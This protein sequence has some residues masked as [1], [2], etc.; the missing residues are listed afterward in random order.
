[1]SVRPVTSEEKL[2]STGHPAANWFG[3]FGLL[4]G[5]QS[6]LKIQ[7]THVNGNWFP[8]PQ[9]KSLGFFLMGGGFYAGYLI[10][11]KLFGNPELQRL[12]QS[13]ELD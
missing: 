6:H 11:S 7:N 13:H 5:V 2:H 3:L 12:N 9:S 10:G 1:M 8:T 4:M